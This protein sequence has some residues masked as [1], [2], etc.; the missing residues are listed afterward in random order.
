MKIIT[1]GT[2]DIPNPEDYGIDVVPILIFY[3]GKQ[4]TSDK[5]VGSTREEVMKYVYDAEAK[6]SQPSPKMFL[7]AYERAEKEGHKDAVVITISSGLS[8]TYNAA[9]LAKKLFEKTH[10]MKIH[11]ID[12][13]T[14]GYI[15]GHLVLKAVEFSKKLDTESVVKKIEEFMDKLYTFGIIESLRNAVKSGRIPVL[16]GMI[17]NALSIKPMFELRDGKIVQMKSGFLSRKGKIE[18]MIEHMKKKITGKITLVIL[19]GNVLEEAKKLLDEAK[20]NFDVV[21]SHISELSPAL[22][23]HLGPGC[24]IAAFY[25]NL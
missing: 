2:C 25:Q 14:G 12:S 18:R 4:I 1:D 9:S 17:A 8:G 20:K 21:E 16:K 22:L 24:L 13:K 10:K 11:L 6:T 3:N 5:L 19:H 23:L 7:E 15:L